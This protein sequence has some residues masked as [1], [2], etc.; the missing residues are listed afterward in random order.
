MEEKEGIYMMD[1]CPS[2]DECFTS[3]ESHCCVFSLFRGQSNRRR[4]KRRSSRRMLTQKS[5][6]M[7]TKM[8]VDQKG[9]EDN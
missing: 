7:T 6:K 9:T 4:A 1:I 3:S 8:Q 2:I 5:K